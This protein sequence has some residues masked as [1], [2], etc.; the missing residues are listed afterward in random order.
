MYREIQRDIGL[1]RTVRIALYM[2]T[3]LLQV[4]VFLVCT[5][6]TYTLLHMSGLAV[7]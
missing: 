6:Q 3:Q 1:Y 4:Y 5:D 7:G 2:F